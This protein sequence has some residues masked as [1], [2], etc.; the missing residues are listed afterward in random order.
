M[1]VFISFTM[2]HHV[3]L[4]DYPIVTYLRGLT[5]KLGDNQGGVKGYI[6]LKLIRQWL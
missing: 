4:H 1:V 6:T 5:L 3:I 2:M